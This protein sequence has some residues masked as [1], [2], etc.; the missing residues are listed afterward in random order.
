M[1]DDNKVTFEYLVKE[2]E[3]LKLQIKYFV[4]MIERFGIKLVKGNIDD[5]TSKEN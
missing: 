5:K 2:N 4:D 1:P 3:L